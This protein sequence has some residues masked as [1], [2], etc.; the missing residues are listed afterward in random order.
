MGE[1]I[2]RVVHLL[3]GTRLESALITASARTRLSQGHIFTGR[4]LPIADQKCDQLKAGSLWS[5]LQQVAS[6]RRR[7]GW[8][9]RRWT[10]VSVFTVTRDGA[11]FQIVRPTGRSAAFSEICGWKINVAE[12]KMPKVT[13]GGCA[14]FMDV[15]PRSAAVKFITILL[16]IVKAVNG[17]QP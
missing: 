15:H 14:A 11:T 9:P 6:A 12:S 8:S 13:F 17:K 3:R 2:V 1:G 7:G 5:T 4:T 10:G 16:N